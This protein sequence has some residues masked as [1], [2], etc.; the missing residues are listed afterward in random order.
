[1]TYL[2]ET[3]GPEE[4]QR[5]MDEYIH[6]LIYGPT[7]ADYETYIRS[8]AWRTRALA[9]KV[10]ADGRCQV[11]YSSQNIQAHHRTYA[12]LGHELDSDIIVLCD[13]CHGLFHSNRK[14]KR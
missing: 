12:R 10:R 3:H 11:C 5:I 13:D 6:N 4:A 2:I 8:D 7:V 14:L 1:M 9:A